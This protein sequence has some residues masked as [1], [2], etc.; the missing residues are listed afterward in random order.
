MKGK[1][2]GNEDSRQLKDFD[3]SRNVGNEQFK[4]GYLTGY[5]L[6]Y[7]QEYENRESPYL[8]GK[9]IILFENLIAAFD[10]YNLHQRHKNQFQ[11]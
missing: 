2:H 7:I 11:T 9:F 10:F 1:E 6:G 5:K 4:A 3:R 8:K